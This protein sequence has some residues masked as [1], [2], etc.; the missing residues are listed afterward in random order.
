MLISI[1]LRQSDAILV[2][3]LTCMLGAPF[4]Y[5]SSHSARI[6]FKQNN[7]FYYLQDQY[8]NY[9]I[10]HVLEHGRPEDKSKIVAELRGKILALSQHKFAR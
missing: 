1:V 10:Q 5:F 2:S 8:G 9:V 4:Q 3:L 7:V 6:V